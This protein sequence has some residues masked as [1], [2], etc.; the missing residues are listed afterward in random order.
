MPSG[1][2]G[3]PGGNQER[4][5]FMGCGH[6]PPTRRARET[7]FITTEMA[8]ALSSSNKQADNCGRKAHRPEATK[9]RILGA[10]QDGCQCALPAPDGRVFESNF[11]LTAPSLDSIWSHG[12]AVHHRRTAPPI[13]PVIALK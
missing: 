5:G 2:G 13:V 7:H 10:F 8:D 3:D 12:K 11:F 9:V 1:P 6:F 4:H